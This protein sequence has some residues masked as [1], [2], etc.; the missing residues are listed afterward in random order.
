MKEHQEEAKSLMAILKNIEN[1]IKMS[2]DRVKKS[3]GLP[4]IL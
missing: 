2:G 4:N 3:N 1:S